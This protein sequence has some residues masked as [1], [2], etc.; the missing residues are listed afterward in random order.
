[1]RSFSLEEAKEYAKE[2]NCPEVIFL[3]IDEAD[4]SYQDYKSLR[5]K[6][7]PLLLETIKGAGGKTMITATKYDHF[8]PVDYFCSSKVSF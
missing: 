4:D 2:N 7:T 1:M 8:K 6:M 3:P 5:H